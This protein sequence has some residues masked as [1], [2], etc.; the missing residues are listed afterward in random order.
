MDMRIHMTVNSGQTRSDGSTK[1]TILL[2]VTA[3]F[4]IVSAAMVMVLRLTLMKVSY[5]LSF[6]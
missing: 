6:A 1:E 2:T 3:V 5:P 4:I